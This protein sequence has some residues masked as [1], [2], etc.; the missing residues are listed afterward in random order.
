MLIIRSKFEI[1]LMKYE[2]NDI[3]INT[4]FTS[5][6]IALTFFPIIKTNLKTPKIQTQ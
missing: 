1:Q 6:F 2:S 4:V 3:Y 5:R